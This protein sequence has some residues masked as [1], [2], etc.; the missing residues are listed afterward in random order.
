MVSDTN[1]PQSYLSFPV[2][3]AALSD[4]L[5]SP[6]FRTAGQLSRRGVLYITAHHHSISVIKIVVRSTRFDCRNSDI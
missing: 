3:L 1:Y 2:I 5:C 4:L 6:L